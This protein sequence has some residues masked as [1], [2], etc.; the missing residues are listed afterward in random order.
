[1][2]KCFSFL[3]I[4]IKSVINIL[5][6]NGQ[7]SRQI[8]AGKSFGKTHNVRR[9]VCMITSK[10]F[11]CSSV[12]YSNFVGNEMDL[13]FVTCFAKFL[14]VYGGIDFHTCGCLHQWFY[15]KCACFI[16]V[17]L[18]SFFSIFKTFRL[19]GFTAFSVLAAIAVGS[20]YTYDA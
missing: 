5:C 9:N 7:G 13:I 18:K 15:H 6:C 20:L 14:Q 17:L 1:M 10:Q 8:T 12:S 11:T 4:R 16:T 19:T 3:I 2:H